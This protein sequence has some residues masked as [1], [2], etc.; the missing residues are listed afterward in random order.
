MRKEI[1][2]WVWCGGFSTSNTKKTS[3]LDFY[4][5]L[6]LNRVEELPLINPIFKPEL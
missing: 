5:I 6:L 2:V 3:P 1:G 4:F